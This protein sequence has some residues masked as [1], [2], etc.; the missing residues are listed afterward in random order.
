M[1]MKRVCEELSEVLRGEFEICS[2]LEEKTRCMQ[3][4]LVR[5]DIDLMTRTLE[6]QEIIFSRLAAM[7][8][9]REELVGRMREYFSQGENV[10]LDSLK[11]VLTENGVD[12]AGRQVDEFQTLVNRILR[13]NRANEMLVKDSLEKSTLLM[14]W[15][16][17]S[18]ND[19]VYGQN[20]RFVNMGNRQPLID[21]RG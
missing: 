21:H 7:E 11:R 12:G 15:I 4:S 16:H 19:T 3:D 9:R 1:V 20:G 17:N 13:M 8:S 18:R 10:T 6:E 5:D 14:T 2:L